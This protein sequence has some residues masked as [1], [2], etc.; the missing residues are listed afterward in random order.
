MPIYTQYISIN[1]FDMGH[2]ARLDVEKVEWVGG[3]RSRLHW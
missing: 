3:V 2:I 1:G